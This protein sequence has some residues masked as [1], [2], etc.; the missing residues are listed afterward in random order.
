MPGTFRGMRGPLILHRMSAMLLRYGIKHAQSP[1][2]DRC[3]DLI[4]SGIRA[5]DQLAPGRRTHI[6]FMAIK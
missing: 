6:E 4:G 1:A 3:L 5:H 2:T